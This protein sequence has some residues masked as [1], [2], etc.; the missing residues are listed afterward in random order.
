MTQSTKKVS[1]PRHAPRSAGESP[2]V[3]TSATAPSL[4][5][6]GT[7]A[8]TESDVERSD[9]RL[10]E[11]YA[12]GDDAAFALLLPRFGPSLLSYFARSFRGREVVEDL[13]QTT[14]LKL[15]HARPSYRPG[16]TFRSWL[17]GIA[18]RVRADELRRR[19]RD[20]REPEA[21]ERASLVP[22]PYVDPEESERARRVRHAIAALPE[23]Q[24]EVVLLH[25][26]A[27]LSFAEIADVLASRGEVVDE[28][29]LR[30]RAFRAYR[31][32]RAAL[33]D[34]EGVA[35]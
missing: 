29:A 3:R 26:Y 25:R 15:H 21:A 31:T 6:P 4:T 7:P 33:A 8:T 14:I 28:V 5:D 9:E 34:L 22:K 20:V 19:Y 24:R 17:F 13:Y 16:A 23:S 10:M 12:A 1:A 2:S 27:D 35:S 18:V 11:R 30:A 32:L